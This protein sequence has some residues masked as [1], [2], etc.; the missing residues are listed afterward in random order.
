MRNPDKMRIE[1]RCPSMNDIERKKTQHNATRKR[2]RENASQTQAHN[3]S[4]FSVKDVT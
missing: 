1:V 2:E 3:G 4:Y